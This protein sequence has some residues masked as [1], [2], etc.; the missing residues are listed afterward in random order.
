VNRVGAS[1]VFLALAIGP[2]RSGP[3]SADW[4]NAGGD[5]D[6]ARYSPLRQINRAN[7]RNLQVA[8]TYHTGDMDPARN[9]TLE[10]SPLVVDGVMHFTSVRT[11][12]VALDAATGKELSKCAPYPDAKKP[13]N[14]VSGGVNRGVAYWSDGSP[15]GA[16]RILL[17]TSDGRLISPDARTGRPDTAFGAAGEVD[18]RVGMERNLS[19]LSYGM[20]SP[21]AGFENIVILGFTV[22][23]G[24]GAVAPGDAFVAVASPRTE[25][26]SREER[27]V[28]SH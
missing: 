5:Q 28:W 10:C 24:P 11:R 14:R 13:V 8:W 26:A 3:L 16:R 15:A 1:L 20:T 19:H 21:P 4:P 27:T 18:L 9:T 12:V 23:E 6:G 2:A 25:T 17:G 22:G 7:V